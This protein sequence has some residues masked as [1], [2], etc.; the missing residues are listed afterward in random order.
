MGGRTPTAA[1][2]D[3]RAVAFYRHAIEALRE[4]SVPFLV[5]GAYALEA[6]AG[7]SG[8]TKDLDLFLRPSDV[9]RALRA[10]AQSGYRTELTYPTWLAKAYM[11]D[12]F[13]DL[14]FSSGN[15]L[16]LVD[17]DWFA[18]PRRIGV[19]GYKL[20][21][22]PIEEII[23]QKAFIMERHRYDGADVLHLMR[24]ADGHLDAD[25]LLDRFGMHWRVLLA[26]VILFDYVYPAERDLLPDRLR[27]ELLRRAKEETDAQVA[28][29]GTNGGGAKL[30]WG[31]FLS[32]YEYVVD[33]EQFGM[34]DA[35]Q[36]L[37]KD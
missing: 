7:I 15:G 37:R 20:P 18:N 3:P 1:N 28:V 17:D 25:R 33:I 27:A 10:L 30:C 14:I 6:H 19:L 12:D 22:V 31:T 29:A 9:E 5:G 2:L 26:H 16:G 8:R 24:A 36:S 34:A 35:R 32:S 23:W 11:G 4:A 13:V 21:L